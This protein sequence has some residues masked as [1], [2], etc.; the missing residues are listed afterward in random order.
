MSDPTPSP[1]HWLSRLVERPLDPNDLEHPARAWES[2]AAA[3]NLDA[4]ALARRIAERFRL[5]LAE[6]PDD[7]SVESDVVPLEVC[8]RLQVVALEVKAHTLRVGTCNPGNPDLAQ[9]L[10][11]LTGREVVIEVTPPSVV[12]QVLGA[13]DSTGLGVAAQWSPADGGRSTDDG[14]D[15]ET[16][17]QLKLSAENPS[18]LDRLVVRAISLG[19]SDIHVQ[20]VGQRATVRFRVDGV[21]QLGPR[22]SFDEMAAVLGRAKAVGGMDPS[23]RLRAQDG[24][25]QIRVQDRDYDLRFST[26]PSS[27]SESLVIRVLAQGAL[28]DLLSYG[29]DD[30]SRLR[31]KEGLVDQTSGIFIVTGPTGHGKTTLLYS[32]LGE[33]NDG[34]RHIHT[35]EDPIEIRIP[36][37][38]QVQINAK[39]GLTFEA[40]IRSLMRQDPDVILV[41]E[42]RDAET[43][44][45]VTDAAMTG[46]LVATTLHTIDA[47]TALLRL[48]DLG[49]DPHEIAQALN[50]I[51]AQRLLRTLCPQCRESVD[52]PRTDAEIW[53]AERTGA[54]PP[55][56]AVG[57]ASCGSSGYQGR[58]PAVEV[59][60]T[61]PDLLEAFLRGAPH[62]ELR[63]IA[64]AG[65]M[66]T[67]AEIVME[68]VRRG[69][70]D[71]AELLRVMGSDLIS[72]E[73]GAAPG[74]APPPTT[75]AAHGPAGAPRP[76]S[77]PAALDSEATDVVL[78][79]PD[80]RTA[81]I[82]E[83]GLRDLGLSLY[84]VT[85]LPAATVWIEIH[86]PSL[87]VLD[88]HRD[89][90]RAATH[91]SEAYHALLP[92]MPTVPAI[93]LVPSD[94]PTVE[95]LLIE[96]GVTDYLRHPVTPD[97]VAFL[98]SQVLRRREVMAG[99]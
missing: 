82:V 74:T 51:S 18:V 95:R 75:P 17:R 66:R 22:L 80:P 69:D 13:I 61:T 68:R 90:D 27:G 1:F 60:L 29:A 10:A 71:P 88:L 55:Y 24:R 65:G 6:I 9:E 32:L 48:R 56:R 16:E 89:G 38:A 23:V 70:T 14:R 79:S 67:M 58:F 43:A 97:Q 5:N 57:C 37:L 63:R 46:H 73:A 28:L 36:G 12:D 26:I 49:V 42:T 15:A 19:A 25:G 4:P 98:A 84:T 78:L 91:L 7:F 64:Q 85:D 40:S 62:T 8:R 72:P 53:F 21:L 47:A 11:F 39:A 35:I 59:L 3:L 77:P 54:P 41:S 94:D 50:G 45:A 93:V 52:E 20:A 86:A 99:D 30:D 31:L 81:R 33:L 92:F 83:S 87:F 44:K 2:A 34:T 76:D 96:H